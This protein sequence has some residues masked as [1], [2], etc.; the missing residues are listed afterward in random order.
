[1]IRAGIQD[2]ELILSRHWQFGGAHAIAATIF[3]MRIR[4]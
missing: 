2:D 4:L 1:M 3:G